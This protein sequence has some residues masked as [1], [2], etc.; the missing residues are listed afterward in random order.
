MRLDINE[1][2]SYINAHP[3]LYLKP[4]KSKKGFICPLCGSGSG[5]RGTGLRLNPKD[6]TH[7]HYK[8][9]G[10][11][12][13]GDMVELIAKERGLSGDSAAAFAAARE[14]YK[15]DIEYKEVSNM[16]DNN[17]DN[18]IEYIK[19]SRGKLD[20]AESYLQSRGIA[21]D[22]AAKNYIGFDDI[23]QAIVI[24]TTADQVSYTVR[25]INPDSKIRYQNATGLPVGLYSAYKGVIPEGDLFVTEGV[26]D[27]LSI[28]QLGYKAVALNS[29][30][31]INTFIKLL[32]ECK[33]KP[34]KI[35]IAMDNDE[36]GKGFTKTLSE[37]LQELNLTFDIVELP[38]GYKD[39]NELLQHDAEALRRVLYAVT[40]SEVKTDISKHKIGSLLPEFM[41]YIQDENNNRFI[42]TG[43]KQFDTAIG[44]GLYPKVYVIGAIPSL[45][46][47]TFVLQIADNIAAAGNDVLIFSLEMAKEDLIARSISKHTAVIAESKQN[48]RLAKT[49]LGITSVQRYKTYSTEDK[50]VIQDA[51]NAYAAYAADHISIYEGRCTAQAIKERVE[52]YINIEGR[53]PLVIVDYLQI[54]EPRAELK[55]GTVREQIDDIMSEFAAIRSLYKIPVLVIS[56]FNRGSYNKEADSTAFKES[57]GIEYNADVVITLELDVERKANQQKDSNKSKTDTLDGL[58]GKTITLNNITREDV[59]E[60][61]LKFLKN[62][63]NRVGSY[64]Y[65]LYY[66]NFN[67]FVEDRSKQAKL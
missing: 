33:I 48:M 26:F 20:K 59:R 21:L 52:Q 13:Y 39:V 18:V 1:A 19:Q 27:A 24:P 54:V 65:Y 9:F 45:G 49:E 38:E 34:S 12:F 56:S 40:H 66:P 11:G 55:R 61:K 25:Y 23:K 37:A 41:T 43:F 44:G 47:T 60:I 57:G 58:R 17:N 4:D 29:G 67:Y 16:S 46:K 2:K 35:Y 10:C 64:M 14:I 31:N 62:R 51:Y 36:A 42:S 8:C 28:I 5:A 50:Q 3:E 7:T 22:I 30:S 6:K 15:I 63:G 53:K 32:S